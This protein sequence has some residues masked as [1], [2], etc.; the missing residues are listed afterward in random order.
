[1]LS[2][3]VSPDDIGLQFTGVYSVKSYNMA[4]GEYTM[5]NGKYNQQVDANQNHTVVGYEPTGSQSKK[6]SLD[7]KAPL[8]SLERRRQLYHRRCVANDV[9]FVL[10]LIGVILMLVETEL[11]FHEVYDRTELPSIII[12]SCISASTALLVCTV[13]IYHIINIRLLMF[14]HS[15]QVITL[16]ILHTRERKDLFTGYLMHTWM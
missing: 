2:K 13:V 7:K 11:V 6:K 5:P 9:A 15:T 1:M 10:A 14:I 16:F 8:S 3:E 4:N 12:K